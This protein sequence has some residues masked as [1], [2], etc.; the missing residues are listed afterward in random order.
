MNNNFNCYNFCNIITNPQIYFTS[1]AYPK[2]PTPELNKLGIDTSV[3]KQINNEK[4]FG[5]SYAYNTD[6]R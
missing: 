1:T 6:V 4:F 3:I 5:M 2:N